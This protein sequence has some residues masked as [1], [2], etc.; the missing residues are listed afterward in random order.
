MRCVA[1]GEGR[2]R[3]VLWLGL[4]ILLPTACVHAQE[5]PDS[6]FLEVQTRELNSPSKDPL[7]LRL[8]DTL[9]DSPLPHVPIEG[10]FLVEERTIGDQS[11]RDQSGGY[12]VAGR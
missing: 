3:R 2:M 11:G 10:A 4:S 8:R 6:P 1:R 12:S 9:P 7:Y 5:A